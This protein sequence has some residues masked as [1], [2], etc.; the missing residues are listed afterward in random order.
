MYQKILKTVGYLCSAYGL[1]AVVLS[2]FVHIDQNPTWWAYVL[3][4]VVGGVGLTQLAKLNLA[5]YLP[6]FGGAKTDYYINMKELDALTN[7]FK[8]KEDKD[9][10]NKCKDLHALLFQREYL[11]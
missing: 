7:S 6:K 5:K 8:V 9:G 11:S 2:K 4:S 10:L 3:G 1:G